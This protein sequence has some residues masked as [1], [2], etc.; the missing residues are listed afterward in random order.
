MFRLKSGNQYYDFG[1]PTGISDTFSKKLVTTPIPSMP[2]DRT[3][4]IEMG[5]ALTMEITFVRKNPAPATE[6]NDQSEDSTKWC[7]ATW[8]ERVSTLTDRWQARSNGYTITLNDDDARLLGVPTIEES[9]NKRVFITNATYNYKEGFSD[10]IFGTI[11]LALTNQLKQKQTL[12]PK[13]YGQVVPGIQYIPNYSTPE[14]MQTPVMDSN[15]YVMISDSAGTEWFALQAGRTAEKDIADYAYNAVRTKDIIK[16]FS[17]IGGPSDPFERVEM[18]LSRKELLAQ[19]P[20]LKGDIH[21]GCNMLLLSAAGNDVLFIV[22][23]YS[24]PSDRECSIVAYCIQ[25]KI[26]GMATNSTIT[27]TATTILQTLVREA[28]NLSTAQ[29]VSPYIISYVDTAASNQLPFSL[30]ANTNLWV[31]IQLCAF[32]LHARPFF[33]RGKFYLIDYSLLATNLSGGDWNPTVT[34]VTFGP[35]SLDTDDESSPLKDAVGESPKHGSEGRDT[36]CNE[37][38]INYWNG[39]EPLKVENNAS[40]LKYNIT[41]IYDSIDLTHYITASDATQAQ[42]IARQIADG[43]LQYRVE[44]QQSISFDVKERITSVDGCGWSYM[45]PTVMAVESIQSPIDDTV[46]SGRS[47][48]ETAEGSSKGIFKPQLLHLSSYE[49]MYPEHMTKYTFG[50]VENV[51]LSQSTSNIKT[52]IRQTN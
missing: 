30:N 28:W 6:I 49:R 43:I 9:D 15:A 7:N 16:S 42:Q 11:T 38:D 39:L 14:H 20:A 12:H 46:V 17:I 36:L 25:Q 3:F 23:K 34:N 26:C 19:C 47:I 27:G 8:L 45:F 35:I 18:T 4:A 33:S 50:V 5:A 2:V 37:V 48:L 44:S 29:D 1:T 40:K 21:E 31:G 22:T 51:S 52:Y 10:T 41:C 32:I 13:E 24:T